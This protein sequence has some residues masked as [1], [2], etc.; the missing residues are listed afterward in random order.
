MDYLILPIGKIAIDWENEEKYFKV[1]DDG[2]LVQLND[3]ERSYINNLFGNE[4]PEIVCD[5]APKRLQAEITGFKSDKARSK[6]YEEAYREYEEKKLNKKE[7][8]NREK[9]SHDR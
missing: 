9:H 6:A 1:L 4:H 7:N 8:E 2:S 3:D 5:M